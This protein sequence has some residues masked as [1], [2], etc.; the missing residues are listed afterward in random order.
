MTPLELLHRKL[1]EADESGV[2]ASLVRNCVRATLWVLAFAAFIV[3]MVLLV[4]ALYW[5]IGGWAIAVG[6]VVT[7]GVVIGLFAT[8]FELI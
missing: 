5:V 7:L 8:A 6:A 2:I 3:I 4:N 1:V